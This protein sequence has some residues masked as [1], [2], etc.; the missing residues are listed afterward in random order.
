MW[1]AAL[2]SVA[3]MFTV[4]TSDAASWRRGY[5]GR[6]YFGYRPSYNFYRPYGMPVYPNTYFGYYGPTY[7]PGMSYYSWTPNM[8]GG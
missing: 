1:L 8:F 5:Y 3:L 2:A 6:G 4:N 7:A